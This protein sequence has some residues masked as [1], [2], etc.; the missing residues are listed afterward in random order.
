MTIFSIIVFV[1]AAIVY[2]ILNLLSVRVKPREFKYIMET[3]V[4]E[5]KV[6]TMIK[7]VEVQRP[8]EKGVMELGR[9]LLAN[10]RLYVND[11]LPSDKGVMELGRNLLENFRFPAGIRKTGA[12]GDFPAG[13][14]S[15]RRSVN[16]EL[17]DEVK[18][19]EEM[20]K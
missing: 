9:N 7:T 1:I 13:R 15:S 8:K 3:V 12:A 4:L 2:Y 16:I 17:G 20:K 19:F 5:H 11:I 6:V 10:F 14:I 18:S